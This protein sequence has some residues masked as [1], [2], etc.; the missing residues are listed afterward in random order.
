MVSFPL[1]LLRKT[2]FFCMACWKCVFSH[3]FC[4]VHTL[5]V[6]PR[7]CT[8]CA[9]F[10]I[11]CTIYPFS[12]LFPPF[13]VLPSRILLTYKISYALIFYGTLSILNTYSI[14]SVRFKYRDHSAIFRETAMAIT[15]AIFM[16]IILA[17][18]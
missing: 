12:C 16:A 10:R 13:C 2:V 11:P 18:I 15:W 3:V 4:I 5:I 6:L 7:L 17:I 14:H 9:E 1:I 8:I